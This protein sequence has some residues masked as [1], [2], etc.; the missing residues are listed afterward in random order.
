MLYA[1]SDT[2]RTTT[3]V[4]PG[5]GGAPV[6]IAVGVAAL[7]A[8]VALILVATKVEETTLTILLL[9]AL[10]GAV[11]ALGIFSTNA[12]IQ[13]L[14][15]RRA[16][17]RYGPHHWAGVC[18]QPERYLLLRILLVDDAGVHLLTMRGR[19]LVNWP[20]P[21]ITKATATNVQ[22]RRR[23][24]AGLMLHTTDRS[25]PTLAF[26]TRFGVGMSASSAA[27]AATAITA[28]LPRR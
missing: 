20:W 18:V 12:G 16:A 27:S 3:P 26:P 22:F 7:L 11:L 15:A 5:T 1:V 6:A 25:L 14:R 28:R 21:A 2:S 19:R 10:M 8:F 17:A 4:R 9:G 24:P 23:T 13:R